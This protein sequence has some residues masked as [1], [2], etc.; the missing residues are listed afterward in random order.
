MDFF[1]SHPCVSLSFYCKEEKG[2][3]K[4]HKT[5]VQLKINTPTEATT[6]LRGSPGMPTR[7]LSLSRKE[8]EVSWCPAG[9]GTA[10]KGRGC[11][12]YAPWALQ[13]ACPSSHWPHREGS[14]PSTVRTNM[15]WGLSAAIQPVPFAEGG[16]RGLV[17]KR[18]PM[19][20][21]GSGMAS[22]QL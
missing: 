13:R 5:N 21:G 1:L 2:F 10:C 6:Q 15:L 8:T 14:M 3:G 12:F 22:D 18:S 7:P 16:S 20:L 9:S 11:S 17:R 19:A 4:P